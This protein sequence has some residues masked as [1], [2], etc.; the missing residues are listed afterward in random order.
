[1]IPIHELLNRIR[2]DK[3]FA[4]GAFR[5]G[6]FDRLQHRIIEV[7][8]AELMFDEQDHFSFS[9]IDEDGEI[10]TVPLH[11]VRRVYKDGKLIWQRDTDA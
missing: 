10:H 1:M 2:W 7:D 5:I 3:Q 8:L 4:Q 9:V 11:R 6:Y